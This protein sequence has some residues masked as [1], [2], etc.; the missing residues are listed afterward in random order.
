MTSGE[1]L[2]VIAAV[3]FAVGNVLQQKGTLEVPAGEDDPRFL[4]QILRRPT[5]LAGGI[6]QMVGWVLQAMAL[7]RSPL[8]VVQSLTA[9]SLVIA[10]PVGAR[11][12]GQVLSLRVWAG[13]FA[14]VLGIVLFLS[15]GSPS[16]GTSNPPA[17]AWW[18]AGAFTLV[19]VVGGAVAGRRTRG[20]TKALVYGSAAGVCFALQASVT[21]VFVPLVGH[22]IVTL[23]TSWTI[24]VLIVSA[25]VGFGLQQS[26]LKTGVLAPAM[27]S[28]NAVTLFFSVIFGV[29]VFGE[30]MAG[31]GRTGAA[32]AGLVLALIGVILLAGAEPPASTTQVEAP[33]YRGAET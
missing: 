9:L 18:S 3:A 21:K 1:T 13:A 4:I 7:D 33:G 19:V 15:V 31:G 17:A 32:V 10:L 23:L 27:A 16:A 24:Y 30:T 14:M 11:V 26:A 29:S 2:A 6:L 22:G 20:A 12:T 8:M 25:I 5:W 28:S